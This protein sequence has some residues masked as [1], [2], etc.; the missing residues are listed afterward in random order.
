MKR[1]IAAFTLLFI[2]ISLIIASSLTIDR[3]CKVLLDDLD[4]C[5]EAFRQE[6]STAEPLSQLQNNWDKYDTVLMFFT[7]HGALEEI[8]YSIARVRLGD[9][10]DFMKESAELKERLH[11]LR[12]SEKFSLK[13][14]S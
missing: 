7:N 11:H 10:E 6:K 12:I 4:K 9:S 2:V 5:E 1:L 13:T 8:G 14:I 3:C